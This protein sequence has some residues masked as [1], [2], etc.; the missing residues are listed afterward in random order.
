[1]ACSVVQSPLT[2]TY[3]AFVAE[4]IP[5]AGVAL[6]AGI[7]TSAIAV[8][9][10]HYESGR[11]CCITICRTFAESRHPRN[12]SAIHRCLHITG[13]HNAVHPRMLIHAS[14][15]WAEHHP[16][17]F[18]LDRSS[19]GAPAADRLM[20]QR[21]AHQTRRLRAAQPRQCRSRSSWNWQ[22]AIECA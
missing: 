7:Q 5:H 12:I 21:H 8:R 11:G 13:N 9:Q 16:I 14:T 18:K 4:T 20:K 22:L 1:M 3:L 19:T 17:E 15:Q 6:R 10:N 2:G